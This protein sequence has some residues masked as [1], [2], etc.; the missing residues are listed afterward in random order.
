MLRE[1]SRT[2]PN[3]ASIPE[4]I[5]LRIAEFL[6]GRRTGNLTLNVREGEVMGAKIEEQIKP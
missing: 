4:R 6:H 5:A 3:L 2:A 1:I